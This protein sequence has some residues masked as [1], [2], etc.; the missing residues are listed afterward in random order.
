MYDSP[1]SIQ[2]GKPEAFLAIQQAMLCTVRVHS[3]S[4]IKLGSK[5]L[6]FDFLGA[7]TPNQLHCF[8]LPLA[9]PQ[10]ATGH[11]N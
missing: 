2:F 5:H 10:A 4:T 9:A 3:V 8:L 6:R 1:I 11:T 7:K